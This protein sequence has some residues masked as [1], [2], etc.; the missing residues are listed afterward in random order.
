MKSILSSVPPSTSLF[1][2]C[3]VHVKSRSCSWLFSAASPSALLRMQR[4]SFISGPLT[5]SIFPS[6]IKIPLIKIPSPRRNT[7]SN[8]I[9]CFWVTLPSPPVCLLASRLTFPLVC[10]PSTPRLSPP[11]L[12]PL[13]TSSSQTR[14]LAAPAPTH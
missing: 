5:D 9:S 1:Y 4:T 10:P 8:Q 3:V 6:L 2:S 12:R 13:P 14:A 11:L 7:S